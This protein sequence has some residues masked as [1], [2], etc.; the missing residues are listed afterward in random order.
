MWV[1]YNNNPLGKNV[2]DCV[3]RAISLFLNQPWETTY[4]ELAVK[5]YQLADLQSSDNVWNAY[6]I[7]KGCKRHL[8]QP[9]CRENCLTLREFL[10][11]YNQGKIMCF[12]GEHVVTAIDGDYYDTWDSGDKIP[13]YFYTK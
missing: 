4:S 12:V 10:K 2:G 1:K 13:I 6:L 7:E 5:G 11:G 8:I 9:N 3:I